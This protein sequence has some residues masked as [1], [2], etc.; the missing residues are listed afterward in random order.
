M[1]NKANKKDQA[2][3]GYLRADWLR[4]VDILL[5]LNKNIVS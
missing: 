2:L 4:L 3:Y 1:R 5:D